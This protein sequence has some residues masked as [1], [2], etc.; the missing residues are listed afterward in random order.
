MATGPLRQSP[1]CPPGA[2]TGQSLPLA[3]AGAAPLPGTPLLSLLTLRA[4]TYLNTMW[5]RV[6]FQREHRQDLH[7]IELGVERGKGEKDVDPGQMRLVVEGLRAVAGVRGGHWERGHVCGGRDAS[8]ALQ[9]P[10]FP[11]RD[12]SWSHPGRTR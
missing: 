4:H 6:T 8:L 9:R 5:I 1:G 11:V 10:E 3:F 12:L 2:L 7:H